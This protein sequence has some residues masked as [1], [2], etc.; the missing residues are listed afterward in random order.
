MLKILHMTHKNAEESLY[1]KPGLKQQDE[2]VIEKASK[3]FSENKMASSEQLMHL[4]LRKLC[5]L[6]WKVYM[7]ILV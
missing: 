6:H 7:T 1:K 2:D 5:C 3:R 4:T